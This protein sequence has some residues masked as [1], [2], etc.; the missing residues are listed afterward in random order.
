MWRVGG[1]VAVTGE[2][3]GGGQHVVLFVGV[4]AFDE[5]LDLRRNILRILA[6]GTD[7]DDGIFGVVVDVGDGKVDPLHAESAGLAGGHFAFV[8]RRP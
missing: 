8:V 5:G 4:G 2:M 7:V 6:E 3:L 1:G